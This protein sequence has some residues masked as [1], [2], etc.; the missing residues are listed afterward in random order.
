MI[1]QENNGN[2]NELTLFHGSS[3][4]TT[5][6]ICNQGFV[7]N[8]AGKNATLYGKGENWKLRIFPYCF[9]RS[10][11]QVSYSASSTHSQ[12]DG[13]GMKYTSKSFGFKTCVHHFKRWSSLLRIID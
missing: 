10:V 3:S 4:E 12:P 5:E 13:Q 7:Q 6:N 1:L 8:Y 2:A 9:F 11:L